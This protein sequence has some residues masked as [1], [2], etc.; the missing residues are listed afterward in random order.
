M[1]PRQRF[2]IT[3][4]LVASV[5]SL[6]RLAWLERQKRV[7]VVRYEQAQATA[8]QLS[9]ER[10]ALDAELAQAR[11]TLQGQADELGGLRQ[12]LRGVQVQLDQTLVELAALQQ[13]RSRLRE[14]TTSLS[15][16]LASVTAQQRALEAKLSSLS[17]LKQ[18]IREV[19]RKIWRERWAAW[20]QRIQERGWDDDERLASGNRGYV[21]QHGLPTL[22][23]SSPRLHVRVL[24]PSAH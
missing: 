13:E 16:Q 2:W 23:G 21:I 18:A 11:Q 6:A 24:E 5:T 9:E 7:L 20:R 3:A 19:K 4:L 1:T 15:D 22:G 12:E 17:E 10:A 8:T 14:E